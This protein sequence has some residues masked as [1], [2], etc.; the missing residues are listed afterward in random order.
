MIGIRCCPARL[1]L[2]PAGPESA[3]VCGIPR[4]GSLHK[5]GACKRQLPVLTFSSRTW[6]I[7]KSSFYAS[8]GANRAA[9][10]VLIMDYQVRLRQLESQNSIFSPLNF[11][12]LK[13]RLFTCKVTS[14]SG[15]LPEVSTL[16][17]R[18]CAELALNL[19]CQSLGCGF[20][21]PP[22]PR[23]PLLCGR[24]Q[25]FQGRLLDDFFRYLGA[26]SQ[27]QRC[28]QRIWDNAGMQICWGVVE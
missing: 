18:T 6:Q 17:N 5:R 13:S 27:V 20:Q 21:P 23:S 14:T 12:D 22:P 8:I 7:E 11:Q 4:V 15:F 10:K 2:G 1:I 26:E 25:I 24:C 16:S 3:T 9:I 28:Q 19:P